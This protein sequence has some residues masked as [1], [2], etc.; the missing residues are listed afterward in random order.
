MSA[1]ERPLLGSSKRVAD[2]KLAMRFGAISGVSLVVALLDAVGLLLLVPLVRAFSEADP[3]ADLPLLGELPVEGLV[4]LVVGFFL[5]KTLASAAIRWWVSGVVARASA[6]TSTALFDAYMHAPLEF[7][8]T[9][10]SAKVVQVVQ[11]TVSLVFGRGF[12]G[13]ATLVSEGAT[14]GVLA[15]VVLVATPLP[16]LVGIVYFV[17]S[18]A[19]YHRVVR[20]RISDLARSSEVASAAAVKTLNE[21]MG[22]LREHRVRASA[23]TLVAAYNDHRMK[24]AL[25]Q[26]IV[27]FMNELS[28][29]YLE[30]WFILG[31]GMIA[32]VTLATGP[33]EEALTGL[34]LLLGA[35]FRVL[36]SIS[37]VLASLTGIR[38]GWS[39]LGVVLD[40]LDDLGIERLRRRPLVM[41]AP[42]ALTTD[43][44]SSVRFDAVTFAYPGHP[45]ALSN[46]TL[47]VEPGGSLG[48]AGP[49]GAGK[50]TLVDLVCGVRSP[51]SGSVTVGDAGGYRVGLVPQ[52]VYLLDADIAHNVAFG[53]G[54]DEASVRAALERA[55]L[56]NFVTSLPDGI[57]TVVGEGG[58]RLSGGQRQRLGIAR[59]LYRHP[60]VLVLD[61]ATAALDG[62][63]EAGVVDA[64]EALAGELT[65]IIVAH[66]LSTI[67]RCDQ[68]A[69]LEDG[70]LM[71]VGTFDEVV[72]R[73]PAFARAVD[74]AGMTGSETQ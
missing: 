55:Q 13:L 54:E 65:V 31:F 64:V 47:T 58:T 66:R 18:S 63:T 15:L 49:S 44:G 48:V 42:P 67:R 37:R 34:A 32:V 74:L 22:G 6:E 7:H 61:E 4:T 43:G 57:R 51:T 72:A 46:V 68:I 62:E 3:S 25:G 73:L 69:Y 9:R 53:L 52:D 26:R 71:T 30:V 41:V 70:R 29:Y 38:A 36:P 23:P 24:D 60:S 5:T 12:L 56:W 21:G 27:N 20:Q 10:N 1:V 8:D 39:S 33:Q 59:A 17:L 11:R 40:D 35:G 50:S 28:R 45:S 16:A 19:L 2:R 14:L